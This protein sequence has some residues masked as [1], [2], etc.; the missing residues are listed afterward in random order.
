MWAAAM[1]VLRKT[2]LFCSS[3]IMSSSSLDAVME[4]TPTETTLMP[5]SSLHLLDSARFMASASS[6][7]W[8]GRAL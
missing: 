2:A 5:R 1:L 7:V 3:L 4:L 8:P 6:M